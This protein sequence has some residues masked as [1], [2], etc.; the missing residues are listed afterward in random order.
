[1]PRDKKRPGTLGPRIKNVVL[2]ASAAVGLAVGSLHLAEKKRDKIVLTLPTLYNLAVENRSLKHLENP[3]Q[4]HYLNKLFEIT[5]KVFNKEQVTFGELRRVV[6]AI[7]ENKGRLVDLQ[8][9][10]NQLYHELD[11]LQGKKGIGERLKTIEAELERLE[12]IEKAIKDWYAYL[13]SLRREGRLDEKDIE[14]LKRVG[15]FISDLPEQ[16]K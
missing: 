4:K 14:I 12:R 8:H 7:Q 10:M 13:E 6:T 16:P 9:R 11:L 1:V 15:L 2:A 3:K 5:Q